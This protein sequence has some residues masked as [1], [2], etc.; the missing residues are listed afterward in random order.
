MADQDRRNPPPS[1]CNNTCI[2]DS[3]RDCC[4]GCLRTLGEIAAWNSMSAEEQWS[5]VDD[6]ERRRARTGPDGTGPQ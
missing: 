4:V 2:V 6:L 5:L 1:P 3:R